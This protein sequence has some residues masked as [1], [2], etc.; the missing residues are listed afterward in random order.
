MLFNSFCRTVFRFPFTPIIVALCRVKIYMTGFLSLVTPCVIY[1]AVYQ[2]LDFQYVYNYL[3]ASGF[4]VATLV[5]FGEFFRR[6]VGIVY[7]NKDDTKVIL[8]EL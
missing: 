5:L 6:C 8:T 7:I 3:G 1:S 4:S 2:N